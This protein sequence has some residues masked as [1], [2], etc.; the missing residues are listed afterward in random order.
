MCTSKKMWACGSLLAASALA[1]PSL[2]TEADLRAEVEQ[3]RA[4]RNRAGK[5]IEFGGERGPSKSN[6]ARV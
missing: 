6:G 5:A 4:E 1:A 2:A 3:L